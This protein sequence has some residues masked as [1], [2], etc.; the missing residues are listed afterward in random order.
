M[1]TGHRLEG[2]L[3][4]VPLFTPHHNTW[5]LLA[6]ALPVALVALLVLPDHTLLSPTRKI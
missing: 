3:A 5:F 2:L 6:A 1:A 4:Q